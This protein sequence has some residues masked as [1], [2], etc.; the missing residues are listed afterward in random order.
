MPPS[1]WFAFRRAKPPFALELGSEYAYL[2]ALQGQEGL[3]E[4]EFLRSLSLPPLDLI[5]GDE[6][7]RQ[8]LAQELRDAVRLQEL[9]GRPL[10]MTLAGDSHL[11]RLLDLPPGL[12][13][14]ELQERVLEQESELYLPFPRQDADLDYFPLGET[15][16][17]Q[18]RVLLVATRRSVTDRCRWLAEAI[19]CELLSLEPRCLATAR[20][21][22]PLLRSRQALEGSVVLY[23]GTDSSELTILQSGVP[24]FDRVIGIGA[25][26][27]L[28]TALPQSSQIPWGSLQQ[29]D[30]LS[31]LDSDLMLTPLKEL[32]QDLQ[33]SL[34]F[35][36]S[37]F[38][39]L[40]LSDVLLCGPG[41]FLP[42]VTSLLAGQVGLHCESAD[43]WVLNRLDPPQI[44]AGRRGLTPSQLV[45]AV[46]MALKEV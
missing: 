20:A 5:N 43:P 44:A 19:G 11:L 1:S 34:R 35:V 3:R 42:G 22:R 24:L 4:V 12:N 2:L 18:Q 23:L 21:L 7:E 39:G 15:P 46:G 28:Q 16:D 9:S 38:E 30:T 33:R 6:D 40:I 41:A 25:R 37:Q 36:A 13:P 45:T 8:T 14:R 17:G 32:A 26:T 31:R 10:R 29:G 27:L